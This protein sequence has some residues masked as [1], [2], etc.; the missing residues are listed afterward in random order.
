[1]DQLDAL[2]APLTSPDPCGADLEYADPAFAELERS[3]QGKPEQQIGNT[4]VPATDPEWKVVERQA[5]ALLGRTKDLRVSV[6]LVN[7]LLRTRGFA[8]FADG[9]GLLRKLV[10]T[11]WEGLHPRLD[12]SDDNDPT[13]RVNILSSLAASTVVAAVRTLPIVS[14]RTLGTFSIKDLEAADAGT[15]SGSN[16]EGQPTVAA[17]E[18]ASM[19]CDIAALTDTT[20]AVRASLTE[21]TGLETA[22]SAHLDASTAPSFGKLAQVIRKAEV[23]LGGKL[24]ART[25]VPAPGANGA[26]DAAGGVA[27]AFGGQINSRE[28]VIKALDRIAAYYARH[29]PSSPIPLFME[30]CKRMV[31]M[32]FVDIVK[33]LVP[34]ALSQ[35]EVLKGRTQ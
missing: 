27:V 29:E 7:A 1:M 34:D 8:G 6:H 13:M 20:T 11:Y 25:G 33:E 12:P 4:V 23:F 24:S 35:V 9:L 26:G 19:D 5:I 10:E 31:M 32:S 30:R 22:V 15:T 16:G 2:L 18:A 3:V 14:S 21:L 17:I 28:D